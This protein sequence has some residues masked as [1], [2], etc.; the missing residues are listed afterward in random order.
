M[1]FTAAEFTAVKA[2]IDKKEIRITFAVPLDQLDEA[3]ELTNFMGK[4]RQDMTVNI[5]PRQLPLLD[6]EKKK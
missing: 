5:T 6:K 1:Q 3:E 2:D 4:D